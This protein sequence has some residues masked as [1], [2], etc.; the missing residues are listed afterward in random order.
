MLDIANRKKYQI[1]RKKFAKWKA[2]CPFIVTLVLPMLL[3]GSMGAI[4]WAIRGTDGWGGIDG[5]IIPGMTWA[6][7]WYYLCYLK[8]IDSRAVIFWL[9]LGIAIGGQLGYGQYVSWIMG[10]FTIGQEIEIMG[11]MTTY[12][13][14]ERWRGYVW[15]VIAGTSWGACGGVLLGWALKQNVTAKIWFVRIIV[16]L[17]FCAFGW[18]LVKLYPSL[19]FPHFSVEFYTKGNCPDCVRTIYTNT[20]NFMVLMWWIGVLVVAMIQKDRPVLVIASALG[21][22]FGIVFASSAMW[23]LGNEFAPQYIDW[24]KVW[25]LQTGFLLGC[26]Y[27]VTLHWAT[28]E[29]DKVFNTDGTSGTNAQA[30]VRSS[31]KQEKYRSLSLILTVTLLLYFLFQG[32]SFRISGLLGFYDVSQIDQYSWPIARI[33]IFIPVAVIIVSIAFIKMTRLLTSTQNQGFIAFQASNI[34]KKIISL[35]IAIAIVGIAT[36]WPSKIGV[37]YFG[38]LWIALFAVS[39]L[40]FFHVKGN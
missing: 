14:I 3:F 12:L 6:L 4:T 1:Y 13:E 40:E 25:E 29:V 34:H 11:R 32:S 8:G 7:L 28:N 10:R 17:I 37:L 24:W 16:P 39:Q 21:V 23:F 31:I 20:Q 15:F 36:I 22:G 30:A 18:F 19:F 5:T 9:G 27:A 33:V 35:L 26:L 38:L 2:P